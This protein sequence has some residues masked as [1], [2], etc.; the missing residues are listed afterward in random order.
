MK[1]WLELLRISNLPTVWTNVAAGMAIGWM[2]GSGAADAQTDLLL[3]IVLILLA[4][5]C[6]Y[7]GGMVLNDIFDHEIDRAE[8]PGRPIPSGRIRRNTAILAFVGLMLGGIGLATL[9]GRGGFL[10]PVV[11][12]LIAVFAFLYNAVHARS[13]WSILFLAVCRGLLYPL[14]ALAI[15]PTL[16]S[17]LDHTAM[18]ILAVAMAAAVIHT[19]ALSLVA[20]NEVGPASELDR[21]Y[22]LGTFALAAPGLLVMTVMMLLAGTE[23]SQHVWPWPLSGILVAVLIL[24]GWLVRN[25]QL[26]KANPPRV[27]GFVLGSI[28]AF[29]LFDSLFLVILP[30]RLAWLGLLGL[31]VF[32]IV[33]MMHRKIPGT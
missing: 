22:A 17:G 4:A 7:S 29:P 21:L 28:A 19:I 12:A 2:M 14:G 23:K 5:S 6:L 32:A 20:R 33:R 27:T 8:R 25:Q 26:L 3:P 10:P 9:A 13:A 24:V 11:A 30:G 18:M 15:Q 1:A 16:H 31:V